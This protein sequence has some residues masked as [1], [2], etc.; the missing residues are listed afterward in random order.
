MAAIE[1]DFRFTNF[2]KHLDLRLFDEDLEE[3]VKTK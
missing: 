3:F 1:V 2:H